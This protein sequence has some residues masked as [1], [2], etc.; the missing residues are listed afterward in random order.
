MKTKT[1]FKITRT[2]HSPPRHHF[3]SQIISKNSQNICESLSTTVLCPS[4]YDLNL[5]FSINCNRDT[6]DYDVV[7]LTVFRVCGQY[8]AQFV[9]LVAL[10]LLAQSWLCAILNLESRK[11]VDLHKTDFKVNFINQ[12]PYQIA[13]Q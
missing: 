12:N 8:S 5:Y 9:K 6:G 2:N 13:K 7:V 4:R 11:C 1:S 3:L 10:V